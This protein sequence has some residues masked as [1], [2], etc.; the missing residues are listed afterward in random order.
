MMIWGCRDS[1]GYPVPRPSAAA[2]QFGKS[3]RSWVLQHPAPCRMQSQTLTPPSHPSLNQAGIW[4]STKSTQKCLVERWDVHIPRPREL[5]HTSRA[6]PLAVHK[7][8]KLPRVNAEHSH[9]P[10]CLQL[11]PDFGFV[12]FPN[13][14]TQ[15]RKHACF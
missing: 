7:F 9:L 15:M 4:K 1:D 8:S 14:K 12:P 2:P 5:H 11:L 3:P 6:S 13:A 10:R